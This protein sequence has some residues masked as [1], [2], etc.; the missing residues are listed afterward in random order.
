MAR[1]R[2]ALSCLGTGGPSFAGGRLTRKRGP[3]RRR[4][5]HHLSGRDLQ[6][7]QQ[8]EAEQ[9]G[10]E[11]VSRLGQEGQQGEAGA[12]WRCLDEHQ[13]GPAGEEE[14]LLRPQ[15]RP[16]QHGKHFQRQLLEPPG[17]GLLNNSGMAGG[18]RP[19]SLA[20]S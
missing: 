20:G 1:P 15:L 18:V 17:M 7:L 19:Q 8:A 14:E 9:L 3:E 13:E 2:N 16:G 4:H 10:R 11:E 6:R 5:E 12:V